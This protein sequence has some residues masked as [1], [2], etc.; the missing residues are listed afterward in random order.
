MRRRISAVERHLDPAA[1]D[2]F[3]TERVAATLC[4]HRELLRIGPSQYRRTTFA[5]SEPRCTFLV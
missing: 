1:L 3:I 4:R 2:A 5:D